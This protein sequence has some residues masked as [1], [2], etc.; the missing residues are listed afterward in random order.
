SVGNMKKDFDYTVNRTALKRFLSAQLLEEAAETAS[1]ER[2]IMVRMYMKDAATVEKYKQQFPEIVA[3]TEKK[4]TE[5]LALTE[6]EA[7]RNL[8]DKA[9]QHFQDIKQ[10]HEVLMRA[11]AAN[12]D[13]GVALY[14]EQFRP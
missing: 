7:G 2:G 11:L 1:L 5:I 3:R 9:Q 12:L 10:Q 14:T 8:V 13:Q 4:F 6:T